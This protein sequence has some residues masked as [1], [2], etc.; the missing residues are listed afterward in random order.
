[1][2][3]AVRGWH[4]GATRAPVIDFSLINCVKYRMV[5][6]AVLIL[7]PMLALLFVGL[8][9]S[10]GNDSGTVTEVAAYQLLRSSIEQL[11]GKQV[12][13]EQVRSNDRDYCG[14]VSVTR[15][16]TPVIKVNIE[17]ESKLPVIVHELLH[18]KLRKEGY[19]RYF[20]SCP[21]DLFFDRDSLTGIRRMTNDIR[22]VI[23]HFSFLFPAM[24]DMG[25]NPHQQ[26]RAI[27]QRNLQSG[28]VDSF[29]NPIY[30]AFNYMKIALESND[31]QIVRE[32]E[33][34]Y[35][36][37]N[38]KQPLEKGRRLVEAVK[39]ARPARPEDHAALTLYCL[40]T[41]FQDRLH[42]DLAKWVS[43]GPS[44]AERLVE[45]VLQPV[46]G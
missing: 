43:V 6:K 2:Y 24:E 28:Y 42:F 27:Y 4:E 36:K 12:R 21:S 18:L 44:H 16:G 13:I 41:L 19:P 38:W 17:I 29:T 39:E 34:H 10:R 3:R 32:L 20:V 23:E 45:I 30:Q 1:M 5:G 33:R 22:D 35:V 40:N 37:N 7:P 46:N 15:D 25:L 9:S 14:E 26:M 31:P 11:Y 8:P